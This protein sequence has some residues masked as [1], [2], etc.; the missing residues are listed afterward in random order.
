MKKPLRLV[1][2]VIFCL[3]ILPLSVSAAPLME[4]AGVNLPGW[5]GGVLTLLALLMPVFFRLWLRQK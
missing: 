4:T 2:Y 5:L 1:L 3:L